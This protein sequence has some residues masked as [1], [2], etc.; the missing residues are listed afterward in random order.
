M[1]VTLHAQIPLD[2]QGASNESFLVYDML[3]GGLV[4]YGSGADGDHSRAPIVGAQAGDYRGEVGL[5]IINH[6]EK[7]FVVKRGERL[8][9]MVI[10]RVYRAEFREQE[11]LD[12][13]PRNSG[14]F[15]HT[16]KQ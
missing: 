6:G 12:S 1:R 16:G 3:G 5:I 4:G 8:A 13:T 7:P 2:P 14:G 15:G 10:S 11:D 9:Q